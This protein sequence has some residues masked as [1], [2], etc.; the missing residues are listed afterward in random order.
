MVQVTSYFCGLTVCLLLRGFKVR[1]GLL[2]ELVE[3]T[4]GQQED[5]K[6]EQQENEK[7]EQ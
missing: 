3:G 7:G 5:E 6:G 4:T 2:I 1:S